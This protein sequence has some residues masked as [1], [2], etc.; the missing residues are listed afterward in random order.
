MNATTE[1]RVGNVPAFVEPTSVAAHVHGQ[2]VVVVR[3]RKGDLIVTAHG[4]RC[5][6]C[7]ATGELLRTK[8]HVALRHIGPTACR[9]L[10]W[11]PGARL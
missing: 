3:E 4:N 8:P 11:K 7:L 9:V 1:G 6:S 5:P 2:H 10:S